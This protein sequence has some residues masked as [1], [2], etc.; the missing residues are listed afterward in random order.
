[1]SI[2]FREQEDGKPETLQDRL[3]RLIREGKAAR[4]LQDKLEIEQLELVKKIS[5]NEMELDRIAREKYQTVEDLR[6]LY[7]K[8]T[9]ESSKRKNGKA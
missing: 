3:Q 5:L 2:E 7:R 8:Q 1:M 9:Q 6:D 4:A